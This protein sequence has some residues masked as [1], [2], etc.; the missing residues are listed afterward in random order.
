M[1]T[2]QSAQ[3]YQELLSDGFNANKLS[4]DVIT[5]THAQDEKGR[6]IKQCIPYEY[7]KTAINERHI[8]LFKKCDLLTEELVNLEKASNGKVDH[9]QNGSKDAADG[10]AGSVYSASL[11]ADQY[12][13]DYG[14]TLDAVINVNVELNDE[15]RKRNMIAD[16]ERE[17]TTIYT[18]IDANDQKIRQ[19]QRD[20]YT[21]YKDLMDGII[22]I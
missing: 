15:E 1:D 9:P 3:M 5:P 17:L 4:V 12:A 10:L 13:L 14:E 7:L 16:F 21:F 8:K 11:F 22:V 20:E 18:E 2:F 6:V 19:D